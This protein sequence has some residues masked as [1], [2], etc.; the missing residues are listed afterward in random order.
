MGYEIYQLSD[1]RDQ[2]PRYIGCSK[3]AQERLKQHMRNKNGPLSS[4]IQELKALNQQPILTIISS[5]PDEQEAK[6]AEKYWIQRIGYQYPL[7][8]WVHNYE[9]MEMW[10]E[11]KEYEEW[12][13]RRFAQMPEQDAKEAIRL[14]KLAHNRIGRDGWEDT[15]DTVKLTIR[16]IRELPGG[17]VP[18]SDLEII[19]L[20]FKLYG[21]S[22][23]NGEKI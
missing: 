1:P 15:Y 19:H 9:A 21:R 20:T 2:L 12:L 16:A 13:Q 8:N 6:I 14:T 10:Q 3:D 23:I 4:W 17:S 18:L 11:R 7:L 5:V 22:P